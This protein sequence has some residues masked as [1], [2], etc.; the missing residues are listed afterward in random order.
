MQ[1]DLRKNS[2][3]HKVPR[4]KMSQE[5]KPHIIPPRAPEARATVVA[6]PA[7]VLNFIT[8]SFADLDSSEDPS[9]P[10]HAP[11]APATS[12]VLHSFYS[13]RHPEILLLVVHLKDHYHCIHMRLLLL[14]GGVE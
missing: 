12:L 8:Y 11:S 2:Q 7:G 4:I 14:S 10:D 9:T 6:S 3:D 1:K 13:S 5:V